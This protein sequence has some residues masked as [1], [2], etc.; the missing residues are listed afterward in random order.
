MVVLTDYERGLRG[1][2]ALLNHIYKT[3]Y[4]IA[5]TRVW[6]PEEMETLRRFYPDYAVAGQKTPPA[7]ISCTP[8][9]KFHV[10]MIT[11][12]AVAANAILVGRD[13]AFEPLKAHFQVE[14]W[15]G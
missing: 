9:V 1:K 15:I 13:K 5:G 4:T 2:A 12:Q 7:D 3:G 14:D 10:L 6:T 11:A 8:P